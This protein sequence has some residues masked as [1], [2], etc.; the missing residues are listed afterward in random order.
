VF[1][2]RIAAALETEL[3]MASG[4]TVVREGDC[5][6]EMYVIRSGRV[7]VSKRLGDRDV[8]LRHLGQGEFF[9]EM[10]ILESLPREATVVCETDVRLLV[11]HPGALLLRIRRDPS[12]AFELVAALSARLRA[13]HHELDEALSNASRPTNE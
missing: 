11:I 4:A 13:M 2:K 1:S 9:G 8:V 12:F 7:R 6:E 3:E 5:G 10:S